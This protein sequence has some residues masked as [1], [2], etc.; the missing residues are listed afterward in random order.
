MGYQTELRAGGLDG[1]LIARSDFGTSRDRASDNNLQSQH[2]WGRD[3]FE[4]AIRRAHT[5]TGHTE[6]TVITDMH[7]SI[8]PSSPQF[9]YAVSTATYDPAS[10][11]ITYT[12]RDGYDVDVTRGDGH[13]IHGPEIEYQAPS[14]G[15]GPATGGAGPATEGPEADA[16]APS[17]SGGGGD[18]FSRL[19][20]RPGE[21][22]AADPA[23]VDGGSRFQA[24]VDPSGGSRFIP[25]D[26]IGDAFRGAGADAVAP[27]P[28]APAG[29]ESDAV[30]A[31]RER[32]EGGHYSGPFNG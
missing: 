20:V 23:P 26:G 16:P 25:A 12:P 1:D 19:V 9:G 6:F 13:R 22:G 29:V 15:P 8:S 27:T 3:D 4:D 31:A 21:S 2:R 5:E 10:D 24:A 18:W 7:T 11:T 30:A 14:G 28:A 17:P 32:L